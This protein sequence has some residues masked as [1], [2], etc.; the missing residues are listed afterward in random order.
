MKIGCTPSEL[1]ESG[2]EKSRQAYLDY[3]TMYGGESYCLEPV[4][5]PKAIAAMVREYDG[6]I[7]TGGQDVD[8]SCYGEER[9]PE[10]QESAKIRDDFELLLAKECLRACSMSLP[11]ER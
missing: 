4:Y 8:P 9:K 7:F 5:D 3:V 1:G 2:E 11:E 6:F 10:C